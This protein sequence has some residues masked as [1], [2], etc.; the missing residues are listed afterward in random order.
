MNFSRLKRY[1][2]LSITLLFL[3]SVFILGCSVKTEID[4]ENSENST[5]NSV[6]SINSTEDQSGNLVIKKSELS[7]AVKFFPMTVDGVKMEA[8]AVKGSDGSVHTSL[9]TCQV[10]YDSGKGYYVQ[11][12]NEVVCQNCKN[13]FAIE[14]I[15][16][17]H[18]GCNPV[19]IDA[20]SLKEDENT[21]TIS[22]DF[23]VKNQA[24][25]LK[26]KK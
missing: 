10:C 15:G 8:L 16:K 14:N 18:G 7:D 3:L 6:T 26:W 4:K 24:L 12:G 17:I 13:R 1:A 11:E 25:F 22:K 5:S 2:I 23:L 21:I 19:P 9:N 20:D